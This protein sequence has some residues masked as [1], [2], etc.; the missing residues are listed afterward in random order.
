MV[1][2][3]SETQSRRTL[4]TPQEA[5]DQ[6]FEAARSGDSKAAQNAIDAAADINAK[7]RVG[8]T[9]LHWAETVRL[10]QDTAA[11]LIDMSSR[12]HEGRP[13]D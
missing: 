7:T 6:L 4:M 9:P 11:A 5:T 13:S 2:G 10:L 8:D 12:S 1:M 3:N